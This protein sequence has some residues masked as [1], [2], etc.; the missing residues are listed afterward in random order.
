[1]DTATNTTIVHLMKRFFERHVPHLQQRMFEIVADLGDYPRFI[2]NC[3]AM[4]VRKDPAAGAAEPKAVPPA[5]R[6]LLEPGLVLVVED[7]PAVRQMVRRSL[8][9]AGLTVLEAENGTQ[10][11]EVVA[12][13][14]ERPKLVLTDVIMPGLNGRELSERLATTQPGLPVLFMSGYTGDDVLARSLLPD[15]AAFIQKPFAPDELVARVRAMLARD[16]TSAPAG[17]V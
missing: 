12:M 7:E 2:P 11:L 6:P 8:E 14:R 13:R 15:E 17:P 4:E 1:M 3:R 16:D 9:A 10:A 5:E